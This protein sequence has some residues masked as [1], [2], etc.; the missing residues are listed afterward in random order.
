LHRVS[1]ELGAEL[2]ACELNEGLALGFHFGVIASGVRP[3]IHCKLLFFLPIVVGERG[4]VLRLRLG[5]W[6]A[7]PLASRLVRFI[8]RAGKSGAETECSYDMPPRPTHDGFAFHPPLLAG[9]A[10]LGADFPFS[11]KKLGV[12]GKN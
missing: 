11:K 1:F 7:N 8:P 5:R 2:S 10:A 6:R 12:F 4:V 9:L 3:V